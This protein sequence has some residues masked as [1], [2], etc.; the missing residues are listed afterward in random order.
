MTVKEVDALTR[1]VESRVMKETGVLLA[2]VGVYSY[3][4]HDDKA[5]RIRDDIRK[6]LAAHPWVVQSH[7]FYLDEAKKAIR[8]DVVMSFDIKPEDGL[9]EIYDE[10]RSAYPE[11]SFQITPDVDVS[12]SK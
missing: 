12:V 9:R 8:F 6:R 1:R 10:M 4:T 11:Y 3:N 2:G 7:G 5:K